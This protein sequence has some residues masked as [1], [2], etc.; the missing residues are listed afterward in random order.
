MLLCQ[1]HH[2]LT[3]NPDRPD[4]GKLEGEK[5]PILDKGRKLLFSTFLIV[6]ILFPRA[7]LRAQVG[8]IQLNRLVGRKEERDLAGGLRRRIKRKPEERMRNWRRRKKEK[9]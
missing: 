4:S 6:L 9:N 1:Y 7:F 2:Q 8:G 3:N 5:K